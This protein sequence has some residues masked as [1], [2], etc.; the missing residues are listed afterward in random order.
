ME[1]MKQEKILTPAE[2]L[3][4]G[5]VDKIINNEPLKIV[6]MAEENGKNNNE[7]LKDLKDE[8][9]QLKAQ[10]LELLAKIAE[11]E[12]EKEED[13]EEK[14]NTVIEAAI[15]QGKIL[16]ESAKDWL[17]VGKINFSSMKAS[18]DAIAVESTPILVDKINPKVAPNNKMKA[19]E[20]FKS[21]KIKTQHEYLAVLKN[22]GG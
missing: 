14:I 6:A 13:E 3:E 19:W 4:W 15:Q 17:T 18:L 1:L 9:E 11:L 8:N 20:D 5:F 16:K 12:K 21:G 7:E 2:A 22:I 10:I